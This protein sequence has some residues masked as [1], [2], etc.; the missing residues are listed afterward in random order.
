MPTL[1][2]IHL[3]DY[4]VLGVYMLAMLGIGFYFA[5]EQQTS[6]DFF[7]AGRSM[8]WFP[9]GLSILATLMSALSYSGN[10]AE[11]YYVGLKMLIFPLAVWLCFPI[12]MFYVLPIYRGLALYSVYEYLELRFDSAT[13][14]ASTLFFIGWRLLWMGGVLFAPC[15]ILIVAGGLDVP[16]WLLVVIL[17]LVSTL[18]T[19]LG[20][21]K[22]VIWTDV[23]QAL[24]MLGG[25][26]L[27]IGFAC[28]QLDGGPARVT[29]VAREFG[30]LELAD[31]K[32]S[33]NEPWCVYAMFPHY[34]LAMLSFYVADQ[35]TAQRFLTAKSLEAAQRSFLF[36]TFFFTLVTCGLMYAGM[37]LLAFYHD[38]P[39]AVRPIWV[40]NTDGATRKSLTYRDRDKL[41][42]HDR[43]ASSDKP[44]LV[45]NNPDDRLDASTAAELIRQERILRPNS[46]E[47]FTDESQVLD[48]ATGKLDVEKLA[49]HKPPQGKVRPGEI[50]LNRQAKDELMPRFIA[51]QLP[52]GLTGLILA[53]LM[54][55]SMSSIDSG[56]NS[57]C[58]LLIMDFHRKYGWGRNWLARRVGKEPSELTETDELKLGRPLTLLIGV[59]ATVASLGVAQIYDIF[60]IMIAVINTFGGPLL[61]IFVLGIFTRRA[62]AAAALTS[63][64]LGT[65]FTMWFMVSNKYDAFAW[66]WPFPQRLADPWSLT[67]GF[68]FTLI[69]GYAL[70]FIVGQSKTRESLRGLVVG[71]GPLG[72]R[73]SNRSII[74]VPEAN[75]ED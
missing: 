39:Q 61:A 56:L 71:M 73:E 66:L 46:K 5:R 42:G 26:G 4:G 36:N 55:A 52:L 3:V 67:F 20:G 60:D 53:A 12:L 51:E 23:V 1:L 70:S 11:A 2:A 43:A 48:P 34:F 44:L 28:W 72:I 16:I 65:L 30:R 35:I 57:I 40:A 75:R 45:W 62:T 29:E 38:H 8:G 21:M 33:W 10:Q 68:G 24:V 64:L 69:T 37:C 74:E 22:A 15:K 41:L 59:A 54:A 9:V 31:T 7:L 63:L 14:L 50:I 18:Y 27:I 32:F 25:V 13:R 49:M 17:G 6:K 58:T 47:P 19:F